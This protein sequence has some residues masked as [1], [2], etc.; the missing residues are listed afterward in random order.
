MNEE[1]EEA[2]QQSCTSGPWQ[3]F[4]SSEQGVGEEERGA[5]GGVGGGGG[6]QRE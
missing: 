3:L 1:E 2:M 6:K 5:G 4:P